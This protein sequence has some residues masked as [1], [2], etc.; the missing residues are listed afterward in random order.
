MNENLISRSFGNN[1][2]V[3]VSPDEMSKH[4]EL[5]GGDGAVHSEKVKT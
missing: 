3:Q 4:L 2:L 5:F 1:W